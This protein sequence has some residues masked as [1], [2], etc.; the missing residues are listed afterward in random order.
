MPDN[1]SL[2]EKLAQEAHRAAEQMTDP[3]C[4]RVMREIAAGY[5]RLAQ[6]AAAQRRN[7]KVAS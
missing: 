2:L 4:K 6:H 5:E 7:M 3:L 1:Q